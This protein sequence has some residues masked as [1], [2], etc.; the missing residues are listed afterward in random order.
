MT[1]AEVHIPNLKHNIRVLKSLSKSDFFCPMVKSNGYGH[2]D[3]EVVQA[4][5]DEGVKTVGVALV[6]E[7][8]RL[9]G[10]GFNDIEI[11]VFGAIKERAIDYLIENRITPVITQWHELELFKR[12]KIK[13]FPVHIKFNTGMNRLGFKPEEAEKL[14]SFFQSN[15]QL[16]L[17]G[18]GTH[19]S[20]GEDFGIEGGYSNMQF[21][22]FN[23]AL[24]YFDEK[25]LHMYN[26]SAF[27]AGVDKAVDQQSIGARLGLAIYGCYPQVKDLKNKLEE[28]AVLKPVMTLKS[29]VISYQKIKPGEKVSYGG[30]WEAKQPS[31]IGVVPIGYTDGYSQ[32]YSNKGVM[33]FRGVEV[34]VVGKVCMD[35]TMVDLTSVLGDE[36]G[37]PGEEI[38][39]FGEQGSKKISL[40]Y[41]AEKVD[42]IPY[43]IITTIGRRVPRKYLHN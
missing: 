30:Y 36:S 24:K 41:L 38:V 3:K 39:L 43:E 40:E 11:L 26:S 9:R 5:I 35:Y 6:E 4:L 22:Q 21:S 7:A 8:K 23:Y 29:E 2:G 1:F 34:P 37:Q 25:K 18:I 28:L 17:D 12:K 10:Y 16:K 15:D 31:V 13:N 32:S 20:C 33:L 27:F 14:S 42:K 19:F